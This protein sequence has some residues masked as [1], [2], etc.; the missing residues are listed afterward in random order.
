MHQQLDL[1]LFMSP[2]FAAA[3]HA[4]LQS[5]I[6]VKVPFCL[7]S[8]LHINEVQKNSQLWIQK[9]TMIGGKDQDLPTRTSDIEK[10]S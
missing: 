5:L 6:F 2:D 9:V 7:T 1:I 3:L 8:V 4:V 10:I